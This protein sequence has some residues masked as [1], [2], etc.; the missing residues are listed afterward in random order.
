MVKLANPCI[1]KLA[2]DNRAQILTQYTQFFFWLED[3][4]AEL[5]C[6]ITTLAKFDLIL[7]MI[8]LDKH[9]L[10]IFFCIKTLTFGSNYFTTYCLCQGRASIVYSCSFTRV[11]NKISLDKN[12]SD[13]FS[14]KRNML[15]NSSEIL[16]YAFMT[17]VEK[18]NNQVCGLL[19]KDFRS[20]DVQID[21]YISELISNFAN[22]SLEDYNK[23][24]NKIWTK[25][26]NTE[27]L[28]WMILFPYYDYMDVKD[29]VAVNQLPQYCYMDHQIRLI[30]CLTPVLKKHM[31]FYVSKVQ[32]WRNILIRCW[33][34]VLFV[35]AIYFI[36][37]QFL[38]LKSLK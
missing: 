17:I 14:T 36:L 30:D 19:L 35:L 28:S 6:S 26:Y 29:L 22:I 32:L 13:S 8:L 38:L 20:L 9:D 11:N 27:E 16:A 23:F 7:E 15:H 2:N 37:Q 34:K 10:T 24:L 33:E 1:P 25:Q 3:H 5:W 31:A 18:E 12:W 4:Y 21:G